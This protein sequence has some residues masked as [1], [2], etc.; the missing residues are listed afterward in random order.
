MVLL[1]F[2][3][4]HHNETHHIMLKMVSKS[5]WKNPFIDIFSTLQFLDVKFWNLS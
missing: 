1:R 2:L 5:A 3:L 4:L